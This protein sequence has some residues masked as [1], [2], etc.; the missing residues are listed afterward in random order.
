VTPSPAPA[1]PAPVPAPP[2]ATGATPS[3]LL[4]RWWLA[5]RRARRALARGWVAIPVRRMAPTLV[6]IRVGGRLAARRRVGFRHAFDVRLARW[7]HRVSLRGETVMV[8]IR[9]AR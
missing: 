8:T 4:A 1:L 5:P 2:G 9:R 7:T 6:R 3:D